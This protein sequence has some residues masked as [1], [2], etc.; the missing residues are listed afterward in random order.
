MKNTFIITI[1]IILIIPAASF[2]DGFFTEPDDGGRWFFGEP[3]RT[4]IPNFPG[5][6]GADS[7]SPAGASATSDEYYNF[8][9]GLGPQYAY[10]TEYGNHH[11][12]LGGNVQWSPIEH[13]GAG[14]RAGVH[15]FP[16]YMAAWGKKGGNNYEDWEEFITI[17]GDNTNPEHVWWYYFNGYTLFSEVQLELLYFADNE[18]LSGVYAGAE[19]GFLINTTEQAYADYDHEEPI[20][21]ITAADELIDA[22]ILPTYNWLTF[23]G[24]PIVGYKLIFSGFTL[25]LCSGYTF[26]NNPVFSGLR[27]GAKLGYS[28]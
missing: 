3:K 28:F 11:I 27:V 17:A 1:L 19:A 6:P 14:L 22:E 8:F 18:G 16:P 10:D 20:Q 21:H 13:I 15:P 12:F 24:G 4:P 5:I 7:D 9:I 2:A 23:R 26:S 25:D